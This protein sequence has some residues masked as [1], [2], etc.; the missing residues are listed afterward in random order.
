MRYYGFM[1]PAH[2]YVRRRT[3]RL[4]IC[5]HSARVM[6]GCEGD[7]DGLRRIAPRLG[8]LLSKKQKKTPVRCGIADFTARD[9]IAKVA[10]VVFDTKVVIVTGLGEVDLRN[11][12]VHLQLTG[13]P[14]KFRIGVLRSPIEIGGILRH[15]AVGLKTSKLLAQGAVAA[16]LGAVG[17]PLAA[18][19]AFADPG[20]NRN[21]DCQRL[22]VDAKSMGAPLRTAAVKPHRRPPHHKQR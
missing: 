3:D 14:K 21:A 1:L 16:V 2:R 22:L 9:G 6:D 13:A 19:A 7:G 5:A 20:L 17:T 4:E 15:P 12:R 8:L 11:E 10:Q 18:V